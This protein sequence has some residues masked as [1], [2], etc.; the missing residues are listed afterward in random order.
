MYLVNKLKRWFRVIT[1]KHI[2]IWCVGKT[3]CGYVVGECYTCGKLIFNKQTLFKC[4]NCEADV[5]VTSGK[6]LSSSQAD[7][8][9][10]RMLCNPCL[11]KHLD[12][13]NG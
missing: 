4:N 9:Q 8:L 7:E 5:I 2:H 10:K 6:E 11:K 13:R 12:A 1:C 3:V